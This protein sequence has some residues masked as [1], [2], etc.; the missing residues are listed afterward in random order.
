MHVKTD[1]WTI[2][3]YAQEPEA[4]NEVVTRQP[5]YMYNPDFEKPAWAGQPYIVDEYG[6]VRFIPE[7][8]KPFS[9][10]SWGYNRDRLT[11][12]ETEERIAA[13]TAVLVENP[14]VSGYC[15]TQLTDIEQEQN[16]IYN[17]DRTPK[18]DESVIRKCFQRKPDWSRF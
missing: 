1:L 15:Y 16:G 11:Q 10:V 18:F 17:Y 3:H 9:E 14:R 7:D 2:H 13:L 5:V 4:L 8:R 6:G 12:S